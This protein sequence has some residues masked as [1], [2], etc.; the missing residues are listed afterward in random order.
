[1]NVGF[2]LRGF[3]IVLLPMI[4]NFFYFLFPK[5]VSSGKPAKH[6]VLDFIEHGMQAI[7]IALLIFLTAP[8]VPFKNP[9]MI[10]IAAFLLAYYVLWI[11]LFAKHRTLLILLCMAVFPVVYF[12]LAEIWIQNVW[13]IAPTVI[14]GVA[15][16]WITDQNYQM[17]N[18]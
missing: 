4:P 1:M 12:L 5:A 18:K 2:S 7:F 13:A 9:L 3:F 17:E 8:E 14:F 11:L 6:P 15:H 10:G 16:A